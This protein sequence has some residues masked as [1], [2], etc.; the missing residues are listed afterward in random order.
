MRGHR[1]DKVIAEAA[2]LLRENPGMSRS[3]AAREVGVAE[4]TLRYGLRRI[5]EAGVPGRGD[6]P[7]NDIIRDPEEITV[8]HRNYSHLDHLYMYP[9]SDIHK[10]SPAHH[11]NRWHEWI[12]YIAHEPN[13]TLILNGDL[14]NVAIV[15]SKSDVYTEE[16]TVQDAVEEMAEELRPVQD[17]IDGIDPGNH[18]GRLIKLTGLD[19]AKL[20]AWHL[21]APYFK[22]AAII[23]YQV[24]E[25]EYEVFVRHGTGGGGKRPGSKANAMEDQARVIVADAYV[26]G[27]VHSQMIFPEE[28]FVRDGDRYTRR[29][30]YFVGSGSFLRYEDYAAEKGMPPTKIGAPRIRL[31]GSRKD[32]HVS[33]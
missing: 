21:G 29:R 10:G 18:E 7:E 20:V 31:E 2:K 27:H 12:D 25:V 32:M 1:D 13:S 15:G 6:P 4:S 14:F 22:T 24:G 9:M 33:I 3:A 5:A 26:T 17:K 23:V 30:Q 19:P 28:V 8:I 16:M 11:R